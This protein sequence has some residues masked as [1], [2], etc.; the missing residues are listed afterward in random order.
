MFR[1]LKLVATSLF[2]IS[3][4]SCFQSVKAQ[5]FLINTNADDCEIFVDDVKVG[6]GKSI[7]FLLDKKNTMKQ[8]KVTRPGYFPKYEVAFYG[9][10]EIEI[11]VDRKTFI[12]E[13]GLPPVVLTGANY[14]EVKAFNYFYDYEMYRKNLFNPTHHNCYDKVALRDYQRDVHSYFVK[15]LASTGIVD[16]NYS[17]LKLDNYK[18][19]L[20]ATVNLAGCYFYETSKN[21]SQMAMRIEVEVNYEFKDKFGKEIY[22]LRK[23]GWS[24]TYSLDRL[25][26]LS[27]DSDEKRKFFN[28]RM[29][30]A[31]ANSL[32]DLIADSESEIIFK[33]EEPLAATKLESLHL[34]NS[35]SVTDMK[36][37]LKATVTIKTGDSFGSGCVVSNDGYIL[38]S[39]HVIADFK[40][41]VIHIISNG[42]DTIKGIVVRTSKSADLAL[43]KTSKTFP[44]AFSLLAST[45]IEV[46]D[47]VVAIGTP[48]SMELSQTVSKGIVSAVRKSGDKNT[49][50]QTDVAVS[51]GNSG[52]PLLKLPG[53]FIG[54]VN[55]K[56]SGG[57]IDGLAFCT[58]VSDVIT[59]LNLNVK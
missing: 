47:E 55:S 5:S 11:N 44:F 28:S 32:Y 18:C 6:T 56:I 22:N 10:K 38:S 57:R 7:N 26:W 48:A 42:G 30:E 39:Y 16:T 58:P 40:D 36:S 12:S 35:S 15:G 41:S 50:I 4:C 46:T 37:A 34:N 54:V 13:S 3:L 33:D 20:E 24:G 59:F 29:E 21:C 23:R 52:G 17:M 27:I 45:E 14:N 2:F 53:I 31:I 19:Q 1:F 49:I 8:I 51:P 9:D 25:K 43:I